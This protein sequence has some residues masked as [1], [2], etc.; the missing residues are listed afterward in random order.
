VFVPILEF[1]RLVAILVEVPGMPVLAIALYTFTIGVS[2]VRG[3][4]AVFLDDALHGS[5]KRF[6]VVFSGQ[7][8]ATAFSS[9]ELVTDVPVCLETN[10]DR[11]SEA[12][13][14]GCDQAAGGGAVHKVK[15]VTREQIVFFEASPLD[16]GSFHGLKD[17]LPSRDFRH[18][19]LQ[20][21]EARVASYAA[22]V[23]GENQRLPWVVDGAG[24]A[25][26]S[27]VF[28]L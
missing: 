22:S 20:D 23:E 28:A 3:Y 15:V 14:H 18:E 17:V 21:Q 27:V 12:T 26:S 5:F 13:E 7:G 2:P 16:P 11:H 6:V 25:L 10:L 8:Y 1:R 19:L 4:W 24:P 9:E